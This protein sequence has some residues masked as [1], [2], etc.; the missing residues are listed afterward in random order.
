[1]RQYNNDARFLCVRPPKLLH[2]IVSD[3]AGAVCARHVSIGN[4][5]V[6]QANN[7]IMAK[8]VICM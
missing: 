6:V 7:D 1:M 5:H 4:G 2:S 8:V 3:V